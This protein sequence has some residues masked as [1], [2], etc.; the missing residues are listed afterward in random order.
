MS[1]PPKEPSTVEI[2]LTRQAAQWW[3][4]RNAL[5]TWTDAD[6][7]AFRDWLNAAPAHQAAY[8]HIE[9][10]WTATARLPRPSTSPPLPTPERRLAGR[11]RILRASIAAAVCVLL[12]TSGWLWQ[13]MRS[14]RY[15]MQAQSQ[16]SSQQ[17]LTLP[18]G[19]AIALNR[20][21]AVDVAFFK[22]HREVTLIRGE[23]FF[24]VASE[25]G[26]PFLVQAGPLRVRVTG[27]AFNV[28]TGRHAVYV[29][30]ARG[31]VEVDISETA[32]R[33]PE[34]LSAGQALWVD[35]ATNK[36]MRTTAPAATIGGWRN[37][38][39]VFRDASLGEVADELS[40]YLPAPI[41]IA[42]PDL[43]ARRLSGFASTHHPQAFVESLPRLLKV[44]VTRRTDGGYLIA[45]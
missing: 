19:S 25:P 45:R 2:A 17:N 28:R 3:A 22:D 26:R 34:K 12:L 39:L 18:D 30:V 1:A 40:R 32:V 14:P 6:E 31:T 16:P 24:E 9:Q 35:Q 27:T 21:T 8:Q 38:Q 13:T 15:Q 41:D 20:D 11:P 36:P 33:H 7:R 5:E 43:A 44:S 29:G 4:D 10:T 42:S 37:G 23:A